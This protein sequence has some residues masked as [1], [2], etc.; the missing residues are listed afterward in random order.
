MQKKYAKIPNTIWTLNFVWKKIINKVNQS[1]CKWFQV[2]RVHH[3]KRWEW[4]HSVQFICDA[5]RSFHVWRDKRA[6]FHSYEVL[7]KQAQTLGGWNA[8]VYQQR[9][10]LWFR[11]KGKPMNLTEVPKVMHTKFAAAEIVL[12]VVSN[13]RDAMHPHLFPPCFIVNA[14]IY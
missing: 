8:L 3:Q 7:A 12:G 4:G 10:N 14:A 11:Q 6:S 2:I 5:E 1:H 9:E 13:E